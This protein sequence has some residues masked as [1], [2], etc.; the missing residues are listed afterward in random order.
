[1]VPYTLGI[2]PGQ[3]GGAAL[4]RNRRPVEIYSFFKQTPADIWEFMN[5]ITEYDNLRAYIEQVH[6]MPKQGVT[7]SFKFGF[8]YGVVTGMLYA[9]KI[10]FELV[11]PSVWQGKLKCRTKGDKNITKT[12]AQQLFPEVKVTHRVAD[13]LL[14]AEYGRIQTLINEVQL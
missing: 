1:M 2:D 11:S 4:L 3:T 12:K 10:P 7:S 13:A 9:A 6:S 5:R 14:I 8:N